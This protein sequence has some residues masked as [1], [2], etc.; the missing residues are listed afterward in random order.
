MSKMETGE[1]GGRKACVKFIRQDEY[2]EVS[3]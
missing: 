3:K 1:G 2:D